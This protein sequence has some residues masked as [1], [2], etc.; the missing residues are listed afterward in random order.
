MTTLT[1][2]AAEYVSLSEAARILGVSRQ[3]IRTLTVDGKIEAIRPWPHTT[4]VRRSDVEAWKRG[5]RPA[6]T[7]KT[8]VRGYLLGRTEASSVAEISPELAFDL[9]YAFITDRRETW[10]QE[11]RTAW[12]TGM[13]EQL[14]GEQR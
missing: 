6:P 7:H 4:L 13:A 9:C 3:H 10:D 5:E 11:D 1:N 12:A 2:L 8:A 14:L